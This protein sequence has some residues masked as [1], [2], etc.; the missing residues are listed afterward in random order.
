MNFNICVELKTLIDDSLE[1]YNFSRE[2]V[3]SKPSQP[4]PVA[5]TAR[6]KCF[7]QFNV[8]FSGY[9]VN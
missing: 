1:T 2:D 9:N 8:D 5:G 4:Q 7:L 6:H 3:V